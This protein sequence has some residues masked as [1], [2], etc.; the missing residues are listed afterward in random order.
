MLFV[1]S[2][3]ENIIYKILKP[4]RQFRQTYPI[5]RTLELILRCIPLGIP[6]TIE[7]YDDTRVAQRTRHSVRREVLASYSR[8][9][10][11]VRP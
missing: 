8:K 7:T 10:K 9:D 11:A 3:R 2:L 5:V 1:F 6:D 4:K